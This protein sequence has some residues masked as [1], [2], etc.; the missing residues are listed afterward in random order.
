MGFRGESP[1][2]VIA[3][4]DERKLLPFRELGRP[5]FRC[6]LGNVAP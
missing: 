4:L 6:A 5:H 2:S 1:R 3:A